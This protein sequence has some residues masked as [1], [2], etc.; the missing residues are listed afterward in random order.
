M[1]ADF[2][3][4]INLEPQEFMVT[5]TSGTN[6]VSNAL[7][8]LWKGN[9]VY[10]KSRTNG[11]GTATFI[12]SPTTHGYMYVTVT[13][14]NKLP[15]EDSCHV[16]TTIL[17]RRL[18]VEVR[19]YQNGGV[20]INRVT[21]VTN[22][23]ICVWAV[24][25]SGQ[26]FRLNDTGVVVDHPTLPS[27]SGYNLTGV[28]FANAQ[29]GY[30]VGYKRENSDKWKGAIWKTEDWGGQWNPLTNIPHFDVPTPFL[31]VH[32]V[33]DLHVW[34][35]CGHGEVLKTTDGG[36][37]WL[38]RAKPGSPNHFGWLWGIDALDANT[39]W[40]CSDQSGL[41]SMTTNGGDSWTNY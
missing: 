30:I 36:E 34:I 25:D 32:A 22:P 33:S 15:V 26:V 6:P 3:D 40:V 11:S 1:V 37:S 19:N 27:G 14:R 24:G 35:S 39:A 20:T 13:A 21:T 29:F 31:D 9:E 5:V 23:Y 38:R 17:D 7:V 10:D 41:I 4:S 2:P 18:R 8:C 28:S 12:I 16:N